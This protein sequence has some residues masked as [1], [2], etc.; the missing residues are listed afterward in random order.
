MS[1]DC[2]VVIRSS[3]RTMYVVKTP[4]GWAKVLM[5]VGKDQPPRLRGRAAN[6]LELAK[7]KEQLIA[8]YARM[9]IELQIAD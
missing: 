9:G 2:K 3:V 8:D 5:H 4:D 6:P 1:N 7:L